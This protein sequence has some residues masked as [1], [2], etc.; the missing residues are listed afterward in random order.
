MDP[1]TNDVCVVVVVVVA[2]FTSVC[3]MECFFSLTVKAIDV[4]YL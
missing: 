3:Q 1:V 2:S 4:S